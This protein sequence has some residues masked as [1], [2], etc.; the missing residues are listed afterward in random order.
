MFLTQTHE[1]WP[2]TASAA[3]ASVLLHL[4]T[5]VCQA[6]ASWAAAHSELLWADALSAYDPSQLH[7]SLIACL[8]NHSL[9][10]R[11]PGALQAASKAGGSGGT[12]SRSQ[13]HFHAEDKQG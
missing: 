13:L 9:L 5:S 8:V 4:C 3:P 6:S 7:V 11:Q 10:D 1:C 12:V 2:Q